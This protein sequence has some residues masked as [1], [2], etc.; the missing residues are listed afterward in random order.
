[1][2]RVASLEKGKAKESGCDA[3]GWLLL[4][5]NRHQLKQKEV[6]A[7]LCNADEGIREQSAMTR[8]MICR[9]SILK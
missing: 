6:R 2:R 5:L 9:G 8:T 3:S 4:P 7:A 1:L